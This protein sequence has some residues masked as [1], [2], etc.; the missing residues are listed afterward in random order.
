MLP[1]F[2]QDLTENYENSNNQSP[3]FRHSD[4]E[5]TQKIE[6]FL[7]YFHNWKKNMPVR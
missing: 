1:E 2:C 5:K 4:S 3:V 6:F 7:Q